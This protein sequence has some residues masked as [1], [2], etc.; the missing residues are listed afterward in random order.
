MMR[1]AVTGRDEQV[2]GVAPD[3]VAK[4]VEDRAVGPR[5]GGLQLLRTE[6]EARI[7]QPQRRPHVMRERVLHQRLAHAA[8]LARQRRAERRHRGYCG[9]ANSAICSEKSTA[10]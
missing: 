9:F 4:R 2:P 7:D 3:A 10:T 5:D 1:G 8:N 6:R